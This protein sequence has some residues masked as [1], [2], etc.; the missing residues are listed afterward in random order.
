KRYARDLEK[1]AADTEGETDPPEYDIKCEALLPVLRG[2]IKA[3]F[4]AHRADDICTALR[5]IKEF[6]LDGVIIHGTEGYMVTEA[7]LAAQV[8]VVCGPIISTRG[9]PELRNLTREN[10]SLLEG[11]GIPTAV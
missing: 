7:L 3:H 11:A 5:I 1:A 8:P 10:L 9:K 2:E 6:S 4:H